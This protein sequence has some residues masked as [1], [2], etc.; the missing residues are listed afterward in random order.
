MEEEKAKKLGKQ[1]LGVGSFAVGNPW[2]SAKDLVTSEVTIIGTDHG[3]EISP[4]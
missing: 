4:F 1:E 3:N 2:V